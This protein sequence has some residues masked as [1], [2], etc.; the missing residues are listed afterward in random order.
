MDDD[1]KWRA[2]NCWWTW[3]VAL[4][5]LALLLVAYTFVRGPWFA[6]KELGS[7]VY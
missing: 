1:A 7:W 4:P 3:V 6:L 5:L 2:D